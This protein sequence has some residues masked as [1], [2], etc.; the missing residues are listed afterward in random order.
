MSRSEWLHKMG[1]KEAQ[2]RALREQRSDR[3]SE[4]NPTVDSG[5]D[6][7]SLA[8]PLADPTGRGEGTGTKQLVRVA[9]ET[10]GG[11]DDAASDVPRG[12]ALPPRPRGRPLKAERDKTLKATE[13]WKKCDPP[14]SRP[15]WFRRQKN[16]KAV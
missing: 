6:R 7:A 12:Q 1:S 3:A 13:P 16:V 11:S 5:P 14:V 4:A 2:L 9:P 8:G 15:T 10:I